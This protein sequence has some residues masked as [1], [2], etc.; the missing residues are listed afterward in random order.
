MLKK[1]ITSLL[2]AALLFVF[3][4]QSLAVEFS[5][6]NVKMD[7][8]LQNNG[9]VKVEE[10]HTYVFDGEFNGITREVIPKKG[11]SIRQFTATEN[12]KNLRIEKEDDLYKIHRKGEDETITVTLY[13]TVKNGIQVY[14]DVAQFYWPFFDDRNESSYENL[15][16]TVHPPVPTEDVI[17][18]GYDAAFTAESIQED[19][20]V[21]FK[22]G[23]VPSNT[24]A[25]IRVAYPAGLFPKAPTTADKPMKKDILKAEQ[26]LIEQAAADAKTKETLSTISTVGIPAFTII[27]LLLLLRDWMSARSRRNDLMREGTQF[28]SVP[29][30]IMSLPATIFFTN[31]HYLQPQAMAAGLLDLVRQG[32]VTKS[33]DD[34]FNRVR[35][36]SPLKHENVLMEWLFDKIGSQHTFSF[37]DLTS[38]TKNKKNHT[39]F[40]SFQSQWR[41]AIKHEVDS[42]SL[43]ENKTT[44]RF[45]I[46][47]SSVLLL[48]FLF[49]FPIYDLLGSFFA[50]LLLFFMVILYACV[51]RPKT[52]EGAQ[53]AYEWRQFKARFKETPQAEWEKWSDD[54]RMRAYIYGLGIS[55]KEVYRKN[56]ELIEA[57]T[58]SSYNDGD[59]ALFYSIIYIGPDT[60]SSF[61]S[62]YQS[63]SSSGDSSSSSG[64]GGGTGGGG[65]GSGA[66]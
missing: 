3:P 35:S 36:K 60:S 49:L 7:A 40:H 23:Y 24:N 64:G 10:T 41:D 48:P 66:F 22:L 55:S 31:N 45:L 58:P 52:W 65:G 47:L 29:K 25:D 19:G 61:R 12:G 33:A 18:F 16:I 15:S 8:Y 28:H 37:N 32:Y 62:A 57:L 21:F 43:Y 6:T 30:L 27:F 26:E 44:Y 34:M 20:S 11:A 4:H 56:D 59:T 63:T 50:A 46:G 17:A 39:N 1:W 2:L 38:Y 13:Y 14:Q 54:E 53:I 42:Y 51:Y 9:D 5:I